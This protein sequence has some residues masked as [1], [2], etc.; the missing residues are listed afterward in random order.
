VK[1]ITDRN[2]LVDWGLQHE[3]CSACHADWGLQ[4]HH[5]IKRSNLRMDRGFNLLRLCYYC[6]AAA[7]GLRV[8]DVGHE[9]MP[10]LTFGMC[11]TLKREADPDEWEPELLR[12]AYRRPLPDL[13]PVPE[14]YQKR[15]MRHVRN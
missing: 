8:A 7:D 4:T 14:Y 3:R 15:R 2:W 6:H 10:I 11:L 13:E 9:F 5:L 12:A 1:P